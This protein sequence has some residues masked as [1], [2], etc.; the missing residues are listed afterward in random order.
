ML[1]NRFMIRIL[2]TIIFM[3]LIVFRSSSYLQ[4]SLTLLV[5][6]FLSYVYF[7]I[8][9]LAIVFGTMILFIISLFF[10]RTLTLQVIYSDIICYL[11][12]YIILIYNGLIYNGLILVITLT[13][14]FY[15]NARL[16]LGSFHLLFS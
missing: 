7:I 5:N 2:G 12:W 14:W 6:I 1:V 9:F 8:C 15:T 13:S 4:R 10:L 3:N 16:Y 11:S